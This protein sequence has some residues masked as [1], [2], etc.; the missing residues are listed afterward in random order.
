MCQVSDRFY[1]AVRV[2]SG[3]GSLKQRLIEAYVDHLEPLREDDVPE[4]IRQ[5]FVAL[6]AAMHAVPP[7]E[8]ET[9]VQVSVRKM[10]PADVTRFTRAILL[11]FAELVRVR[12]TGERLTTGEPAAVA[13]RPA[14]QVPVPGFLV[15][16]N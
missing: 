11:M 14:G 9:S 12:A 1:A 6:V 13:H 2:L 4:P 16:G 8:K 7:T 5:R 10:A 15:S 3:E